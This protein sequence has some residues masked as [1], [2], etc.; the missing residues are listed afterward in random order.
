MEKSHN[1]EK[2]EKYDF[3]EKSENF[4]QKNTEFWGESQYKHIKKYKVYITKPLP[5]KIN[6]SLKY[7][8]VD[9]IKLSTTSNE[10]EDIQQQMR[11]YLSS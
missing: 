3:W 10:H 1:S 4:M 2:S 7:N 5:D 11:N 9:S 8:R 6:K